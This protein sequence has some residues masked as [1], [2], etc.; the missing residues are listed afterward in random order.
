MGCKDQN[1][2][3]SEEIV[4]KKLGSIRP[5]FGLTISAIVKFCIILEFYWKYK[6]KTSL[7]KITCLKLLSYITCCHGNPKT[8]DEI[9]IF[10][11]FLSFLE[12]D[13]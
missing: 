6:D 10:L 1:L 9:M 2:L 3:I 7:F 13:V 8:S 4:K 12:L 11:I 5:S